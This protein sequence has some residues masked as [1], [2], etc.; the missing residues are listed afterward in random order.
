MQVKKSNILSKLFVEPAPH[1]NHKDSVPKIMWGVFVS[2]LPA[3]AWSIYFFGMPAFISIT[4][5]IITCMITEIVFNMLKKSP[6]TIWDGSAAV[7]GILFSFTL[8]AYIPLYV[9]IIGSIFA[10]AIVK[11]LF[12]GLGYNIINPALAARVFVMFSWPTLL[13]TN[14][15]FLPITTPENLGINFNIISSATPMHLLK[16]VANT[17]KITDYYDT[18]PLLLGKTPGA[19][20]EVSVIFLFLGG[21]YLL[22]KKYIT[23][24]IPFT[25]LLVVFLL[26]FFYSLAKGVQIS[27]NYSLLKNSLVYAYLHIISGGLVLGAF[28]MSTDMVTTPLTKKGEIIFAIGIGVLTFLIRIFGAYPEG[29]MFS[30]L[31]MELFVP[32]IDR[33]IKPQIYGWSNK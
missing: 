11:Q 16:E 10:I 4:V 30:I 32:L 20:G 29:V 31:I 33:Y 2:L 1:I 17:G 25:F 9:P 8:P 13:T 3:A 18:W 7:T 14:K 12:G 6:I 19:I 26:T 24:H 22:K 21:L 5:S 28:F 15:Y 23:Y 27:N